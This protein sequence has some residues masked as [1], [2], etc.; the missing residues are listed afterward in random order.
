MRIR[1]VVIGVVAA[2]ALLTAVPPSAGGRAPDLPGIAAE[3]GIPGFA[4]RMT[5]PGGTEQEQIG[6]VDGARRPVTAR[7]PF[8]WGSVSKSVAARVALTLAAQGT[9]DL[10]RPVAAT[11]PGARTWVAPEVTVRDL[12]RHTSGLPH[13]VSITDTAR[14][15][16]ATS[17]LAELP[18][19]V[20]GP[21]G[22]FRYSSLNY[23]L[24]QAVIETVSGGSY[25]A[26][27]RAVLGP[28]GDGIVTGARDFAGVVPPGHL[29]FFGRSRAVSPVLDGA[30]LGYGY[31]AGSVDALAH[32]ARSMVQDPSWQRFQTVPTGGGAD[33]GPGLYRETIAGRTVWWHSGAVP[34]YFTHLAVFPESGRSLVLV[35]NRYGEL[36]AARFAQLARHLMRTAAGEPGDPPAGGAPVTVW[37]AGTLVSAL[38]A[39]IGWAGY[40]TLLPAR[41]SGARRRSPGWTAVALGGCIVVGAAA[42]FGPT[43]AG[44]PP[45]VIARWAPDLALIRV[46][47]TVE[48]A[49]LGA[50]MVAAH[51]R[52]SRGR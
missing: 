6:G 17:A 32:Y 41:R 29:P 35:A 30:G 2:L 25:G 11:V 13:E 1:C 27:V 4:M 50:L 43:A 42:W 22:E 9:L 10:D 31:L 8:V 51:R 26:A 48:A 18:A 52:G 44:I 37:A 47:V 14:E 39:A 36:E 12:L 19:P 49:V 23:L 5:G 21:R 16:S 7:T 38:G 15:G 40:R 3:M 28:A 46:V 45:A 33:Y 24:V 20:P 34:G